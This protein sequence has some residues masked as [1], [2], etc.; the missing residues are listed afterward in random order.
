MIVGVLDL[1]QNLWNCNLRPKPK[2]TGKR[3]NK[4]LACCKFA[5]IMFQILLFLL[6]Q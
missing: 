6:L 3:E 4:Y 2:K 5:V 1:F